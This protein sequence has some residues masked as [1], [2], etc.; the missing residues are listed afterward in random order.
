MFVVN[1]VLKFHVNCSV[2]VYV[3]LTA[4]WIFALG[5][6]VPIGPLVKA[7]I[8][9]SAVIKVVHPPR[10]ELFTNVTTVELKVHSGDLT[11]AAVA[12]G[13]SAAPEVAERRAAI[14]NR[15]AVQVI[16]RTNCVIFARKNCA[17]HMR[18][19]NNQHYD[20]MN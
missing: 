17:A 18:A 8:T 14:R 20:A 13:A 2:C 6:R 11:T 19:Q 12:I 7:A 1:Y 5:E 10:V 4:E 9:V 15:K 16:S 3:A